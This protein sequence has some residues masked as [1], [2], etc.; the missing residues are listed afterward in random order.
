MPARRGTWRCCWRGRGAVG[1]DGSDRR[2]CPAGARAVPSAAAQAE[3][4]QI[5]EVFTKYPPVA[6]AQIDKLAM[7]RD[8]RSIVLTGGD[9]DVFA[10]NDGGATFV[11]IPG[12]VVDMPSV[13]P[14][15]RHGV[16]RLC[17]GKACAI[18]VRNAPHSAS[19]LDFTGA[20]PSVK[21]LAAATYHVLNVR[22]E[23]GRRTFQS[24][25]LTAITPPP[26]AR[27]G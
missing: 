15:G 10:S 26:A 21:P 20:K 17:K 3:L 8:G 16:V 7:S 5:K 4:A 11:E 13:S 2:G 18:S 24:A 22:C 6:D 19:L 27:D 14:D 12:Q 9:Y 23:A 1:C 25:M